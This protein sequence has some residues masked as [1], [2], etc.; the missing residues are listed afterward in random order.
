[1]IGNIKHNICF[2]I[3]FFFGFIDYI[4]LK[5]EKEI[6]NQKM[7]NC[8]VHPGNWIENQVTGCPNLGDPAMCV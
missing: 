6:K 1:M 4:I 5:I 7:R 3:S 8:Q 2:S